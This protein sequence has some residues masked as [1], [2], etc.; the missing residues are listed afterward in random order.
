MDHLFTGL[1][2]I[3]QCGQVHR[4]LK[5]CNG[6]FI[7]FI[8]QELILVL[9]RRAEMTWKIT[10]FGLTVEATSKRARV[11]QFS[12]GTTSYRAPELR[13]GKNSKIL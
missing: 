7:S 8:L 13:I 1:E 4:D 6:V 9:Y 12:R 10:D 3:H 11:T 5:P 2:F